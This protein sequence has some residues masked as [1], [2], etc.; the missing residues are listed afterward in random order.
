MYLFLVISFLLCVH[1]RYGAIL[2]ARGVNLDELTP[3]SELDELIELWLAAT[4]GSIERPQRNRIVGFPTIPPSQ[5][6]SNLAHRF[7]ERTRGGASSSSSSANRSVIPD[8]LFLQIVRTAVTN[9]Q[10]NPDQF[11]NMNNSKMEEVA[12]NI[13]EVSHPASR[14]SFNQL[15]FREV[16]NVVTTIIT[17][18]CNE[19][20]EVSL[21]IFS[22][23]LVLLLILIISRE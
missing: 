9:A 12:R 6:L 17:C 4:T 19:T 15:F 5:L 14:G 23:I 13:I 20:Q 10:A 22:F 1:S 2:E 18:I 16:V 21:L 8:Q 3:A 11:G 7:R